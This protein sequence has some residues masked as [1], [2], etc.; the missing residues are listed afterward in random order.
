MAF[1][2]YQSP[3]DPVYT[4][5]DVSRFRVDHGLFL[6]KVPPLCSRIEKKLEEQREWNLQA[7][8]LVEENRRLTACLDW[9]HSLDAESE[10]VAIPE[11]RH[12]PAIDL[13]ADE[14][15]SNL[16]YDRVFCPACEVEYS[17][18]EVLREAWQFEE[19]GVTIQGRRSICGQGH[20]IHVVADLVDVLGLEIDPD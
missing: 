12:E 16:E 4:V 11:L 9:L 3:D 2:R 17:R 15:I 8:K 1:V 6:L 10:I 20:N 14:L 13:V 19:D 18:D 7:M 5:F